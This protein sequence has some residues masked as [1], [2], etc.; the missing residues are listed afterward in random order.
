MLKEMKK[1]V[2]FPIL[3]AAVAAF[4]QPKSTK[5]FRNANTRMGQTLQI[6]DYFYVDKA[7]FDK[8]SQKGVEAILKELDPHSVFISKDEVAAMNEPLVGNFDGIGVSFQLHSDTIHVVDVIS[9]G[10]SEKVGLLAG[11]KIVR[12]D[13]E[14]ATGDSIKEDWVRKHLRG[15]K[16]TK[17]K[18]DIIRGNRKEPIAFT[19]TRDKIPI[20]SIDTWFMVSKQTGYVKLNRFA[21]NSAEELRDALKDLKKQGMKQLILDLRSNGGG[22]LGTAFEICDEFLSGD[23]L[24]V[25]T[26]GE[27]SPRQELR[28]EVKGSFESGRLVVMVDEYSAS[29]SEI[30]SGAVQD[31]ERGVLVGRRTFGKG[32]VQRPFDLAD[33]SQIRLTTSRYY[34]P[35]GRCIQKPYEDGVEEY[36][37]DYYNRLTHGELSNADSVHFPDSLRYTTSGGRTVYGGGGIMPDVFVPID[38]SR[39]S[40]YLINLRSKGLFNTYALTWAEENRE[41]FLKKAPTYEQFSEQYEKMNVLDDFKAFAA[42]EGVTPSEVKK[43]WV[44]QI[45]LDYLKKEVADSTAEKYQSYEDYAESLTQK[46][47][48]VGEIIEKAK[49]EDEKLERLNRESEKYIASSLKALIARNLYGVKYYYMT[50]FENDRE[51]QEA[52]SVIEDAKRYDAILKGTANQAKAVDK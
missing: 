9:G 13:G 25:Y 40:D 20:N 38:T 27:K 24:I 23:K 47:K 34:T 5:E 15:D 22:Y 11:D 39:A 33:K 21:Q 14:N 52:I 30:L 2:L 12:V 32:L 49:A 45:V 36:R 42:K 26:E 48:L 4:A 17:V 37:N 19:I 10:P 31:W 35:S 1:L 18:V 28:A 50:V 51:L 44:N 46:D 7:D 8:I 16:G 29:A 3:I 6:I 41:T 43:E